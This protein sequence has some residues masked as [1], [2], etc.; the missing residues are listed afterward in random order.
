V[1]GI[2]PHRLRLHFLNVCCRLVDLRH[3]P[4]RLAC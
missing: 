1:Q 3:G 4:S 2:Q